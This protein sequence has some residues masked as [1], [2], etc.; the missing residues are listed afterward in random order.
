M[1]RRA[2]RVAL[3][4]RR[5]LRAVRTWAQSWV[6]TWRSSIQLR[7]T[8]TAL[9]IGVV[10]VMVLSAYLSGTI[11]DGLFDQRIDQVL[12]ES[13]R[14][15]V[16]AQATLSST[17]ASTAPQVQQLLN[18]M[19]PALQAG[20]SGGREV[21]LL[22]SESNTTPVGVLDISTAPQ[23]SSLISPSLREAT[24]E[25]E[26][27]QWQSVAIP[28]AQGSS[29]V[30]G[31]MVGTTLEVPVAGTFE[32]YFLYSF[33]PE[34]QTLSFM[35]RVLGIAGVVLITF[36]AVSTWT[37]ARQVV[38]PVQQAAQVAERLADG[39]LDERLV[40]KGQDEIATLGR[41]F[42][43]MATSL[44]DQ[45]QRLD[46]LSTVQRRFVSDVSHELRTPLT[47]VR[48]A[49][50]MIYES[51][52]DFDP[53]VKRSAEL[54]FTQ[55]DRFEDLLADLLEI[56]R[57]DA[58]AAVLDAESLDLR[59]VVSS[60][61]DQAT[62]LA[63]HKG[64]WLSVLFDDE[65]ATADID[66]RRVERVVRNLL[67]NAVEYA[68]SGPVE[69]RVAANETAVAVHVRDYGIGMDKEQV[70]HVFDRFWRADPARART[71]G[72]TGLG[73][74]ISLEDAL[75][76]GGWLEVWGRPG[77]GAAFRLTLPRRAGIVLTGSPI[78][79]EPLTTDDVRDL[80]AREPQTAGP[81]SL[82]DIDGF[83]ASGASDAGTGTD[84]S[85][86][87]LKEGNR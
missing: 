71:S 46:A 68:E 55:L 16:Q 7:V 67:V 25:G 39:H 43:E 35:Q 78:D 51:R 28:L 32:L 38:R 21:F 36:L 86:H 50:E 6:R 77:L 34:Q 18:D 69:V 62:S 14:S 3:A 74:A 27:Q 49:S 54:L 45:I 17:T 64:V 72:G 57:F 60:A 70:S 11:R 83:D 61:V 56:S 33:A 75:L 42:N 63:A 66:R 5:G 85:R 47:T 8:S 30:P 53:V 22:R 4:V 19:V 81:S 82:P 76:H 52:E 80:D 23:L 9:A 15:A 87:D 58:G 2:R 40:V 13:T 44:Q 84:D 26:G 10:A 59:D 12:T 73:L 65:R 31:V 79:L 20:G 29:T 48:M 24:A 41:S 37:L 1:R